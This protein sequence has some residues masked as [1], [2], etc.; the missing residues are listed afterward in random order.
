[1]RTIGLPVFDT[2]VREI[3]AAGEHARIVTNTNRNSDSTIELRVALDAG[4]A[5]S[6]YRAPGHLRV[7]ARVYSD[8]ISFDSSPRLESRR[9]Y[10]DRATP[11]KLADLTKERLEHEVL[12]MLDRVRSGR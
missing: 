10:G 11:P 8:D 9:G 4:H 12:Q 6:D 3:R 2:F 1:V 7:S 5:H